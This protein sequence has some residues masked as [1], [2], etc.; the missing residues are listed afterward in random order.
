VLVDEDIV[1]PVHDPQHAN[2]IVAG[3]YGCGV[4][5]S[6]EG[7]LDWSRIELDVEDVRTVAF[8]DCQPQTVFAICSEG[9]LL[10]PMFENVVRKPIQLLFA[11]RQHSNQHFD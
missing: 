2:R 11:K 9:R 1:A 8:S 5:W 10:V 4:F 7:G 3:T 6:S